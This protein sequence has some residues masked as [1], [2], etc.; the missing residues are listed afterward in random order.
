MFL[1]IEVDCIFLVW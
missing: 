1:L